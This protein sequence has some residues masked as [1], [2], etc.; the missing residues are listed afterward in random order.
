MNIFKKIFGN[1]IPT[2]E[3]NDDLEGKYLP[4]K[5]IPVDEQFTCNFKA[6]GGKF[7]YCEDE[8][9]LRENF[10]S[11]LQEN[12]W[13]EN[14]AITFESNITSLLKEN[15]LEY[16]NPT[17]PIF[18]LCTCE[19]LVSQDGSILFTSK[20]FMHF[21]SAELPKN[22]IVIG[23]TSQILRTKSDGLRVI[24]N[25]YTGNIPTNISTLTCFKEQKEKDFMEYGSAPKNLYLL[26]LEDL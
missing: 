17:N 10:I 21:K 14:E 13:F 4:E 16:L 5:E 2:S 6:N 12:D 20:Q 15:K 18:I 19:G 26:L 23:R 11:I 1:I 7:I 24:K 25:K 3:Q 22:M 8:E 9:E